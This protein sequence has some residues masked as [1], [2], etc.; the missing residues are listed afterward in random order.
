M[1]ANDPRVDTKGSTK[2]CI[3]LDVNQPEGQYIV[4]VDWL[5]G[6]LKA[7]MIIYSNNWEKDFLVP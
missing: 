7:L 3:C 2:F 1:D 4:T 5:G 6:P